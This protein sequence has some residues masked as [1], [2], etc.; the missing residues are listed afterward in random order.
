MDRRAFVAAF[1]SLIPALV[2]AACATSA[3]ETPAAKAISFSD[4]ERRLIADYYAQQRARVAGLVQPAQGIKAGDKLAPGLR[5]AKLP[6]TLDAQLVRLAEP[7]A[8][9]VLGADV[10][11]VNRNTHDVLDVI[12]QVAY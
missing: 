11:L 10:I 12:A 9:L 7:Y 5:P 1:A 6:S 3:P 8:R 4:A 2:V